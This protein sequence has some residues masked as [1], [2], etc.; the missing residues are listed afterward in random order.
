M[1]LQANAAGGKVA[2]VIG[3]AKYETLPPLPNSVADAKDMTSKLKKLGFDVISA[4]DADQSSMKKA[5]Q[6]FQSRLAEGGVG[7]F[8]FSGH[9]IQYQQKNYIIPIDGSISTAADAGRHGVSIDAVL[10]TL[11]AKKRNFNIV[12][13]D[14]CNDAAL[15]TKGLA[16]MEAPSGTFLAFAASPGQLASGG[17]ERNSLFTEKLLGHI[18]QPGLSI[19]E[20]FQRTRSKI[21]EISSGAQIPTEQNFLTETFYFIP[22][23]NP[24]KRPPEAHKPG[25]EFRDCETCPKMAV[26]P[27][28]TFQM[29]SQSGSASERPVHSV[30]IERPFAIGVHEVTIAEWNACV[31]ER[32]CYQAPIVSRDATKRFPVVNISW[33]DARSFTR[34]LA[35]KTGRPYRL[36]SEA[37]WE[38][39]ARAKSATAFSWGGDAHGGSATLDARGP[40]EVGLH[41]PNGFGLHDVHGNVWEWV[42]DCFLPY[43]GEAGDGSAITGGASCRDSVIRGGSWR[44]AARFATVS[45]RAKAKSGEQ[46]DDLG[47]RVA[48][49]L[50]D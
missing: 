2:L 9:G 8:Y 43:S 12:I 29:G 13:L 28:G 32:K 50:D 26:V 37:E 4:V 46:R 34:W 36:P 31:A 7:L 39:A 20:I 25:D 11:R 40:S 45:F 18:A 44:Y 1:P 21:V 22:P 33:D 48:R 35:A 5:L 38:F 49:F 3:N 23:K 47:F 19:H 15:D 14:A 17:W 24:G 42:E 16:R 41:Q 6:T 10:E 27:A 30:K